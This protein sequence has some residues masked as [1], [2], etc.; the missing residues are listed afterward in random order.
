MNVNA[1]ISR[2]EAFLAGCDQKAEDR[3]VEFSVQS[4]NYSFD[5][6]SIGKTLFLF[7]K[8]GPVENKGEPLL[9]GKECDRFLSAVN[10]AGVGGRVETRA[11]A[12]EGPQELLIRFQAE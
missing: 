11:H 12:F 4:T 7:V 9:S 1:G 6:W 5:L 8:I 3:E 2:V 10:V